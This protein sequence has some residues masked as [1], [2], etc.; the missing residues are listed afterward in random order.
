MAN[1]ENKRRS[2]N[3]FFN[4]ITYVPLA[5]F[6]LLILFDVPLFIFYHANHEMVFLIIMISISALLAILYVIFA[7]YAMKRFRSVFVR[8]LYGIT[9]YNLRNITDNGNALIDYPNNTYEEFVSLNEQVNE[10]KGELDTSTLIAG[11]ANFSHIN[12][13]YIDVDQRLTTFRSFKI[14]L[15]SIIFASQNYRNV[16]IELY[17]DL[18]EETLTDKDLTYLLVLLRK[19]FQDYQHSLFILADNKKSIY[20]YLP[21]IDSLSKV[22]EQ[23]QMILKAA[24]ISKRSADG[25][26]HLI[27][28]FALVCYPFSD[29]H[30]MLPDLQYAKRQGEIINIYLPN[31][32][33][34]LQDNKILKNSMNL[35]TMSKI[36]SP[37][38]NLNLSLENSRKNRLEV[39]KV[40]R[41]VRSYF[42]IDYA[43]IISFDEIRRQYYFSYQVEAKDI[44]PLSKENYIE[45]EFVGVMNKA[46][47]E[48][49]SYYFAFRS[50]ANNA[51]GRHLDRI[52]IESGFYYV[53]TE[54]N[55][56]LG[57]IYFFNKNK[58][59]HID[60]YIQEALVMLCVRIAA[61]LLGEKRDVEVSDSYNEI[62]SLLK[63]SEYATYRVAHDTYTLLRTSKT[64]NDIFPKVA[65]GEKCYKAL[66]GLDKPCPDCPL[67]TGKK[68]NVQIKK[69]NY[70]VSSILESRKASAYH[71]LTMK[72]IHK[73]EAQE[74]YH[75]DLLINSYASLVEAISNCY[76]INGKGYLLLLRIDNHDKLI[77]SNGSEGY[78]IIMRDFIRRIKAAHNSLENV[79]FFNNQTLALLFTEYGQT[80]IINECELIYEI[81]QNKDL[82]E[83]QD[84]SISVTYLPVSYPRTYPT[85]NDFLRQAGQFATRGKYEL[86][87]SFIYFDE[88]SYTRSANKAEF[89][90]AVIESAFGNK[91]FAV[92]L[93]PMV[94]AKSKRI[95]GAELLLRI[96]DDYRNMVFRTDELV[97]VAADHNKIGIIS[98]ALLEYIAGLYQQYS[99]NVFGLLGFQRLSINT[100]YSFF[101]DPN[102]YN[103]IRNYISNSHLPKNFLAFE[104]PESD[105]ANHLNEFKEIAKQLSDLHIVMV[106][107]QYT[108]RFASLEAL[109]NVGFNEVKISRNLVNHIDSDHNR[110][111]DIRLLLSSIKDLDMKA[112]IVGV[113]NVDQYLLLKEIDENAL[114][115]GFY[116][117]RPLEK[118]GLIEAIRGS[119]KA[120]KKEPKV[121]ENK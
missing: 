56:P 69:D 60:S 58:E 46:K 9:V 39:E 50:H 117:F 59:F 26:I 57:A 36:V 100:D 54:D 8:G 15:E 98:N 99:L 29:V 24:T 37:L 22:N 40:I 66:Y 33:T 43:G 64:L 76:A 83:A 34:T 7:V 3:S 101:T 61:V 70:E 53:F 85:A 103:D 95:Y 4:A 18:G 41:T 109:K 23:L 10:L 82:K 106:A 45:K 113:E 71:V 104:I 62:D 5:I 44:A 111:N 87:K 90:L 108:G 47:D 120:L 16:L 25:I 115:Q 19:Q 93:Q 63:I 6:F 80:D 52:G 49:G 79:Y 112:S 78:L 67:L 14:N 72:N 55:Q 88:S 17:Y 91:T 77:D 73:E 31:R 102:F 32:M 118:Q 75:P 65:I 1:E 42:N 48:N 86:N 13:D 68:K 51:L 81:S 2:I 92:N 97:K 94:D 89:M 96:T 74:R 121:E 107:D 119:N 12:L 110:L 20:V 11:N 30:E 27:A 35:N 116:F 114:M 84:Y 21:R 38:L 105:I 28:H